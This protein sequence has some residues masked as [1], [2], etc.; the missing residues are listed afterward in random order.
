MPQRPQITLSR[1]ELDRAEIPMNHVLVKIVR[2][3]EGLKTHGGVLVGFNVD[4]VYAEGDDSHSANMA[5]ICG[6]VEKLPEKLFFDRNDPLSMDWETEIE[7]CEGDAVFYSL[8]E[9]KN[10]VQ[11]ICEGVTYKSI[12]YS[13]IYAFKR[14]VWK[15][16]WAGTKKTIQGA[17][18][19]YVLCR[20]VM[21]PVLSYLDA[22]SEAQVDKSRGIIAFVSEPP[23]TYLRDAYCH[24]DN[25]QVGDEV[26]FDPKTALFYLE[27]FQYTMIFD[28]ANPYWVVQR[29]RIIAVLN[30]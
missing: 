5:E 8:M 15:D 17:I 10:S 24:I 2:E 6:I 27:R 19:G 20:Q 18:N 23:K 1:E 21:M 26:L 11:L 16:K 9:A 7:L 12:P 3:S 30:R 28:N 25:L 14:D 22:I 13:D 4:N 29:R